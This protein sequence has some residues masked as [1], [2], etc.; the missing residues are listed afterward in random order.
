MKPLQQWKVPL[1]RCDTREWAVIVLCYVT[2]PWLQNLFSLIWPKPWPVHHRQFLWSFRLP[3]EAQKIDRMM[4]AFAQRYCH[5]NPGVFQSTGRYTH[6]HPLSHCVSSSSVLYWNCS[7]GK[8]LLS[9]DELFPSPNFFNTVSHEKGDSHFL[10]SEYI[11]ACCQQKVKTRE[12][13]TYKI[14]T[15]HELLTSKAKRSASSF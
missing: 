15:D 7:V 11:L 5:C 4:E 13:E 3:G 10:S 9:Y 12:S 8:L 14:C 2:P 1:S 6:T